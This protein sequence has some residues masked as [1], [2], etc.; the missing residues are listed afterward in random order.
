MIHRYNIAGSTIFAGLPKSKVKEEAERY[1][2]Q[3][4]KRL[5]KAFVLRDISPQKPIPEDPA[6]WEVTE[7]KK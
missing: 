4:E 5:G 6:L 1:R 2:D 7:V 3:Q